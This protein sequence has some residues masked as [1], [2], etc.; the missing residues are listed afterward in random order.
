MSDNNRPVQD[1]LIE[2]VACFREHVAW[3]AS[4]G[5]LGLPRAAHGS[6]SSTPQCAASPSQSD[7]LAAPPQEDVARHQR[8]VWQDAPELAPAQEV[9]RI[10]VT[11]DIGARLTR[12]EQLA[13]EV[14]P[15][16]KC[17]LHKARK[18]TVFA[19]GNPRS[20]ILFV[21]EGPGADEDEQGEPFVGR[22]GQLLD[23][24]IAAM[25]Y[26]RDDV[27]ICNV[28]KCRPPN[29]R[30]PSPEE[31]AVC[32]PYLREQIA[33]IAPRVIVALGATAVRGLLGISEGIT[34]VRGKWKL[35]AASI[36]VMPTFHPAYLLRKEEAKHDAWADLKMVLSQLGRPI[37]EKKR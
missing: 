21:G 33:L 17:E 29:N 20:E 1:E 23:R 13:R 31:M 14:A 4:S 34:R 5:S 24:M 28:V 2:L 6:T 35:Y 26:A 12:L 10:E 30:V 32:M 22:A 19:R 3:Q 25:G 7:A 36:P 37:P 11:T 18:Q 27:Y 9:V 8:S 15:C 16:T